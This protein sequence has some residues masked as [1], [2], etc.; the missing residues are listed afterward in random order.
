MIYTLRITTEEENKIWRQTKILA[1]TRDTKIKA[2][3]F[4]LL[5]EEIKKEQ[6]AVKK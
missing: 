4:K 1:A 6:K 2:L 5:K 3:I